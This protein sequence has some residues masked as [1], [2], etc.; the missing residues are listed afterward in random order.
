MSRLEMIDSTVGV[1][2]DSRRWLM[3]LG[4][5]LPRCRRRFRL[6]RWPVS[7]R[8]AFMQLVIWP[9]FACVGGLGG[10][11][12][13]DF[14]RRTG[15]GWNCSEDANKVIHKGIWMREMREALVRNYP[16]TIEQR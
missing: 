9:W 6:P 1:S 13:L 10:G 16:S 7:G 12:G 2:R 14:K 3:V 8:I 5:G 11:A 4:H 15:N